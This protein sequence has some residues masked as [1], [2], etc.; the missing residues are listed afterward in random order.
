MRALLVD[1]HVFPEALAF[2]DP[3]LPLDTSVSVQGLKDPDLVPCR[4][5]V[6]LIDDKNTPKSSGP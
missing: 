5:V 4:L 6:G 1:V 3:V 2:H